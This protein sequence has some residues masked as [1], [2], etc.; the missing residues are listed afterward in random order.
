MKLKIEP[1]FLCFRHQSIS[2]KQKNHHYHQLLDPLLD[3]V[4]H[5]DHL[6]HLYHRFLMGLLLHHYLE[7]PVDLVDR[8]NQFALEA[9]DPLVDQQ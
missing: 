3:Q 9:L 6:H 5:L 2:D 1:L 4:H 7:Y 8:L